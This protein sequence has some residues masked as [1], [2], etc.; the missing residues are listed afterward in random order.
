MKLSRREYA[1]RW[2]AKRRDQLVR[3]Q[4]AP[5]LATATRCP[6]PVSGGNECGGRLRTT[7]GPLGQTV[8]VCDWCDRRRRGTCRDC[9]SPVN[10]AVGRALRCR[11]HQHIARRQQVAAYAERNIEHVRAMARASYNNNEE[12]RRRRNDQKR[13]WRKANPD[14]VKAQKQRYVEKHSGNPS[15][16]YNRYHRRYRNK[17]QHAVRAR[18]RDRIAANPTPRKTAPKCN[19]CGKA[20]RWKPIPHGGNGK[21]WTV[22]TPCLFPCERKIRV[23]NRR[24]QRARAKAWFAA[25]PKKVKLPPTMAQRGPGWERTCIS[26]GCDIVVTHRKKKCTRCRERDRIAA[27]QHLAPTRG[28]GRRVDLTSRRPTE[29]AHAAAH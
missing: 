2:R 27:E 7:T 3:A 4:I 16:T 18:E 21:P 1:R 8:V 15:S 20:T 9:Q 5:L 22:C 14:K 10:G 23:A 25:I 17:Y 13:A 28:R 26:P 29:L 6:W 12:I 11:G 19:R 24:A